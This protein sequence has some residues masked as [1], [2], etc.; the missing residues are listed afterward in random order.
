MSAPEPVSPWQVVEFLLP[1]LNRASA[2][3]LADRL[4]AEIGAVAGP[5]VVFLGSLLMPGDEVLMCV[6]DGRR[7]DVLAVCDLAGVPYERVLPC[8]WLG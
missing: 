4:R 7:Q 5:E 6:F 1:G 2:Q 3:T 8:E